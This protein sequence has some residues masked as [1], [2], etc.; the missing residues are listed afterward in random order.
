MGER[1]NLL[2]RFPQNFLRFPPGADA[3]HFEKGKNP[4]GRGV[5]DFRQ[6]V[7]HGF[8]VGDGRGSVAQQHVRAAQPGARVVGITP[9]GL[10]GGDEGN[11]VGEG[12]GRRQFAGHVGVVEMAM[13]VDQ[14]GKQNDFAQVENFL[15]GS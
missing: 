5:P 9:R 10:G 3:G 6:Q 15:P 14:A 8:D 1:I 4:Q 13:G 2:H 12:F 11:P 7:G